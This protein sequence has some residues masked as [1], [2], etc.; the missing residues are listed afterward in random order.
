MNFNYLKLSLVDFLIRTEKYKPSELSTE[1]VS[2]LV[3]K[4]HS[5]KIVVIYLGE[6]L[7]K[8]SKLKQIYEEL[9]A[10]KREKIDIL[11]ICISS[12]T[13]KNHISISDLN[14]A[15]FKLKE[16]FPKIT[17]LKL[18]G[19]EQKESQEEILK[20][21][22]DPKNSNNEKL[23]NLIG[24]M[25]NRSFVSIIL[26]S[27]FIIMPIVSLIFWFWTV[28]FNNES[29]TNTYVWSLFF[30]ASTRALTIEGQ[31]FWR[32]FTYGFNVVSVGLVWGIIEIFVI[33]GFGL[34]TARYTEGVI[35]SWKFFVIVLVTYPLA[36]L[37]ATVTLPNAQFS[38]TMVFFTTIITI[39]GVTTWSKKND[40]VTAFSK[41]RLIISV[42][43]LLLF[44]F[45]ARPNSEFIIV[46]AAAGISGSIAIFFTFDYSKID[47]YLAFPII[48]TLILVVLPVVLIFL[49]TTG[50]A[51]NQNIADAIVLHTNYSIIS[52]N[53][54]NVIL[55]DR[56]GWAFFV[57][58]IDGTYRLLP[59][60]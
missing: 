34:K 51:F 59:F 10:A 5:K 39:L 29:I 43:I 22:Q 11:S 2:Y 35:G 44:L 7:N 57:E 30:G 32:L 15:K 4:K 48:M 52:A 31:Q 50:L 13:F 16:F 46:I 40:A 41:W 45:F 19:E 47:F 23:K 33:A 3:N 6:P 8:D 9:K 26:S 54:A 53:S 42:L 36:G 60:V 18:E 28:G 58:L 20:Q 49:P 37:F 56:L 17:S 14:E 38:G 1:S 55:N 24:K 27:I 12:E 25:N 21:L